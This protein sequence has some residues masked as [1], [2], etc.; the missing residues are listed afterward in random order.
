MDFIKA[1]KK[2]IELVQYWVETTQYTN[3]H[4]IIQSAMIEII[5]VICTVICNSHNYITYII[6]LII[7]IFCIFFN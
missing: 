4:N 3:L 6:Y 2:Y 5:A 1:N 7:L